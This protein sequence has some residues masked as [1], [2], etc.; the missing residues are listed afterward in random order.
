MHCFL[1]SLLHLALQ[2]S[3]VI[4][5]QATK[6]Y[7]LLLLAFLT[8]HTSLLSFI[9]EYKLKYPLLKHIQRDC[10]TKQSKG[11]RGKIS[12]IQ[13]EKRKAEAGKLG[14]HTFFCSGIQSA[15]AVFRNTG[16]KSIH[17]PA[18]RLEHVSIQRRG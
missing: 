10:S 16:T 12:I 3:L 4:S 18:E 17:S 7:L 8:T 5:V 15:S 2:N 9:S 6:A 13:D 14:K 11:N 1:T